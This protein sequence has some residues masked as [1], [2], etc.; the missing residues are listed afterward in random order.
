[1]AD[2]IPAPTNKAI[3]IFKMV[4][5]QL[6]EGAGEDVAVSVAVAYEPW[7][8]T[9]VVNIL[10]KWFVS[11]LAQFIDENLYE[12]GAKIIIQIQST[13]NKQA[14]NDAMVP[15]IGGSPSD[16]EIQAA[17]DAADALIQRNRS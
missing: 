15:I 6:I 16:A 17:R 12:L 7:L 10:F 2:S 9:P 14:F 5:D 3:D 8:A 4:L 1:M 13:E 11:L